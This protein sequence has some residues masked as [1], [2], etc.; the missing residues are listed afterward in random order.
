MK[1]GTAIFMQQC[2]LSTTTKI[3]SGAVEV[4]ILFV[5]FTENVTVGD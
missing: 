2:W 3:D 1:C 4:N 5:I